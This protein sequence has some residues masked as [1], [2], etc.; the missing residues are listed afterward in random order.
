[1]DG[2]FAIGVVMHPKL[3][4]KLWTTFDKDGDDLVDYGEFI[5]TLM[6]K[7]K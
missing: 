7:D 5:Q 4:D 6:P 1:M 2:F 3:M